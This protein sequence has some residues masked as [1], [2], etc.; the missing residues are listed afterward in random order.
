M[1]VVSEVT[2]ARLKLSRKPH[3]QPCMVAWI[4]NTFIQVTKNVWFL[5]LLHVIMILYGEMLFL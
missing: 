3:P 1:N 2:V 4:I 5:F